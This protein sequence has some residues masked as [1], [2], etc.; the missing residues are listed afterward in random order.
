MFLIHTKNIFDKR[1]NYEHLKFVNNKYFST[2]R[3]VKSMVLFN[4]VQ[5][6]ILTKKY[7]PS[8]IFQNNYQ[9][10]FNIDVCAP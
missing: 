1:S 2:V 9:K 10:Y 8:K 5:L 7:A 4:I 3:K 6:M